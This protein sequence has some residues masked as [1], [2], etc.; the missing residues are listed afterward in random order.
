MR[1]ALIGAEFEENLAVRYLWGAL[2]HHGHEVLQFVFN[3]AS[4]TERVARALASSGALLA[5]YSMVFTYRAREFANLAQRARQLGYR[6]H[7][8]AGGHFAAFHARQ[9]LEDVPAFDS[10]GCGE[11]EAILCDLAAG[12]D[13]PGRVAGLVW[14]SGDQIVCNPPAVKPPDLDTLPWPPRK[15]PPDHYLGIPICNILSSRG[16]SHGCSFCSIAAW[17]RLCGG[18]RLRVRAPDRVADEMAALYRQ[19]VRIFNFHDDNFFLRSKAASASRFE[20]LR[21][22]LAARGVGRIAFAIKSRPDSVDKDLFARLKSMGLF[23]VFLGIEAGSASSLRNL[24]RGQSLDDN[25]RALRVVN[26]LD[27]HACFNLL[28]FNPESTLGDVAANIEF[29]RQHARNPMN[30]CR[31]EVYAGTPLERRLRE[32]GRLQG[33]YWGLDYTIAD[34]KA[35]AAFEIA[36]HA[37][38]TRNY[39]DDCLHHMTMQVDYEHQLLAHFF[40]THESLRRRVKQYIEE[41]NLNTCDHLDKIMTHLAYETREQDDQRFAQQLRQE[42]ERDNGRLARQ[43]YELVELIRDCARGPRTAPKLTRVA[44]AAGL[45]A[46]LALASVGCKEKSHHT[47]MVAPPTEPG[48]GPPPDVTEAPEAAPPPASSAPEVMPPEQGDEA[49]VRPQLEREA[50]R[51]IAERVQRQ[52]SVTIAFQVTGEGRIAEPKLVAGAADP[53]AWQQVVTKLTSIPI[54]NPQAWG[55]R[56]ELTFTPAQ[57]TQALQGESIGTHRHERIPFPPPTRTAPFEKVPRPPRH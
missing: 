7:Q 18:E 9:L 16:C 17:H 41:V 3:D 8:I 5:G 23:R 57:L 1:V 43:G 38:S 29:L 33:D 30:F 50:L 44:T 20:A 55:K 26:E 48:A 36:L 51:F 35:Q 28:L 53:E 14:R 56:Y 42:V 15:Q 40:G 46:T 47:E 25:V 45:A 19:G 37:F 12:L 54:T 6:G 11:G 4:D 49:L 27:L 32:Q 10:V 21:A 52:Q 22:A 34:P 2:E 39:G 31:T 24:G 13:H